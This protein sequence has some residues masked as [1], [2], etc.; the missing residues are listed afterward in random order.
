MQSMFK[1]FASLVLGG[2]IVTVLL[3]ANPTAPTGPVRVALAQE[4]QVALKG[5][6]TNP[7]LLF[8]GQLLNPTTGQPVADGSYN[9]TFNLYNVAGGGAPLWSETKQVGASTGLFATMLGSAAPLNP[10]IFNGQPLYLGIAVAGDPEAT[11]RQPLGYSA[12][13][14]FANKADTLDGLDST[15]FVRQGNGGIVAYGVVDPNG[16]R[17]SGQRFS[18]RR[19]SDGVYEITIDGESYDL[20]K[21]VTTV[22]VIDNSTCPSAIIAK[23]GS[24]NGKLNVYLYSLSN[25]I[26]AC[27]FHFMTLEP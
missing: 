12:Y 25:Q 5:T 13:A 17:I 2:V 1:L 19:A 9:M 4:P 10:D 16:S 15:D 18:S 20:N 6:A 26:T 21:F 22:T 23:T 11:P 27:K 7:Q 14:V 24:S 3:I 8:Q